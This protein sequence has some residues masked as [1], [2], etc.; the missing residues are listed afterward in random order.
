MVKTSVLLIISATFSAD[1][2]LFIM[3]TVKI[4]GANNEY[5]VEEI[6]LFFSDLVFG[7][8]NRSDRTVSSVEINEELFSYNVLS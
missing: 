3:F 4:T 6:C 8:Y 7:T 1:V 5:L 2:V